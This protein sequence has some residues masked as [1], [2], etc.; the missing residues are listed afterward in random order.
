[1]ME[2]G[3]EAGLQSVIAGYGSRM[4][5]LAYA[6]VAAIGALVLVVAAG[7][8]WLKVKL[9]RE[10]VEAQLQAKCAGR[11]EVGEFELQLWS[12]PARLRLGEVKV[13]ARTGRD[14]NPEPPKEPVARVREAVLE[15]SWWG[16]LGGVLD[17]R[18]LNL[19]GV[20]I[21][22]YVSPEGKS[23]LREAMERP[24]AAGGEV[25]AA[26]R[27][28]KDASGQGKGKGAAEFKAEQLGLTIRVSE[29]R[30]SQGRLFIHNRVNKTKTR[31]ENLDFALMEIDVDPGDLR[32]HNQ[33]RLELGA[34]LTLEGR[35]KVG[36]EMRD[37]TF[38]KLQIKGSGKIQPFDE[39]TGKWS[40]V[41]EW[42][43]ELA[44]GS[45][46]AGYMTLGQAGAQAAK[47]MKNFGLDLS[48]LPMGGELVEPAVLSMG[49]DGSRLLVRKDARF[50][51]PEYE[52]RM[53][54]G[55]WLD[56]T[57]DAQDLK[58]RLVCG[59]D[60]QRRL[61]ESVKKSGVPDENADSLL[62][63]F[64]DETAGRLAF[65]LRVGGKLTRPDPQPAWDKALEGFL[66]MLIN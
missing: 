37:V 59:E 66:R 58:V 6:G 5:K 46:L 25:T 48:D 14:G 65:D 41:T 18:R 27:E 28:E 10:A 39:K 44:K 24:K 12:N 43:L 3:V 15:A 51:M 32:K 61:M 49:F 7:V 63:A 9:N 19:D 53:A 20:E 60:L 11:V 35:G 8:G 36:G 64:R 23:E 56:P 45:V 29:A 54:G 62:K 17:V 50:Q 1:M 22:E 26:G 52:V 13:Y 2:R 21:E 30:L 38:A 34:Q 31:V 16:V 47:K 42:E 57:A 55:S 40:P 33:A 4:K